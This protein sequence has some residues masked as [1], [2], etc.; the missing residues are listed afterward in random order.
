MSEAKPV[1]HIYTINGVQHC[2]I[3][4]P[5]VDGPLYMHPPKQEIDAEPSKCA[6]PHVCPDHCHEAYEPTRASLR[7]DQSEPKAEPVTWL[8]RRSIDS[9]AADG[10]ETCEPSDYG[11]FPVYAAPDGLRKEL[12]MAI[13]ANLEILDDS[14]LVNSRYVKLRKAAQQALEALEES[15]DDV[16]ELRAQNSDLA[17]WERY[18]R[19]IAAYTAQ[20]EKHDAAIEALC[21]ELS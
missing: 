21:K 1:G 3:T 10:Y 17:G 18:D 4:E 6:F 8:Q 16:A 19:R 15:R 5:M 20:L 12:D 14:Q 7:H 9:F 11:A 2:T 13:K